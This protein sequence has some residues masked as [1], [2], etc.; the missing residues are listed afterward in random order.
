MSLKSKNK[1]KLIAPKSS[2]SSLLNNINIFQFQPSKQKISTNSIKLLYLNACSIKN[3]MDE[4]SVCI[5]KFKTTIHILAITE[6]W[7]RA[8]DDHKCLNLKNYTAIT[9]GR[10]KKKR[11]WCLFF[12]S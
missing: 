12:N 1:N 2:P 4:V 9:I 11:R 10:P 5:S 6:T 7:L 3:K 8:N